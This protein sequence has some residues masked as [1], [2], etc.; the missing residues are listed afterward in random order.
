MPLIVFDCPAATAREATSPLLP[1]R[2]GREVMALLPLRE[3]R[4][5]HCYHCGSEERWRPCCHCERGII[6]TVAT[7]GRRRGDGPAAT[8]GEVTALVAL[9]LSILDYSRPQLPIEVAVT[10]AT[11]PCPGAA[12]SIQR[13]SLISR[14]GAIS[15]KVEVVVGVGRGVCTGFAAGVRNGVKTCVKI[16]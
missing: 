2:V 1:L 3:R 6:S 12:A 10:N 4:H 9:R 13:S 5:L 14:I 11:A 7:A 8:A 15:W 16:T